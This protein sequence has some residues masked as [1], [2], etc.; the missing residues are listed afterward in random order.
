MQ[1]SAELSDLEL[2]LINVLQV[3]P[4]V[5]W[6]RAGEALGVDPSTVARTWK[7]LAA[8]GRVWVSAY[9]R[10]TPAGVPFVAFIEVGCRVGARTA[11]AD[12]LA[13]RP[14]AATIEHATGGRDLLV[15]VLASGLSALSGVLSEEL[16]AIDGI[17]AVRVQLA[18]VVA[19]EGGGWRLRAVEPDAVR[20]LA[21]DRTEVRFH[22]MRLDEHDVLLVTELGR[23]A[24][25]GYSELAALSGLGISTVRRRVQRLIANGAVSLRCEVAQALSGWP[26]SAAIWC[27]VPP[28]ELEAVMSGFAGMPEV[29]LC[30]ALT[31]GTAN[32]F[33]SLWVR[34]PGELHRLEGQLSAQ[35]RG[36]EVVDRMLALRHIKRMGHLLDAAGRSVG[37]VP[38][39]PA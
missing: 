17:R 34:S 33:V 19:V 20:R 24:R 9:P 36:I 5:S 21:E 8:S 28:A 1:E 26:V 7:S 39:V 11:V 32:L 35:A 6:S 27:R 15:S 16:E 23:D 37:V 38:V 4:R 25:A 13:E 12:A 30:A 3:D 14:W 22:P 29:R 2:R 31:G 18:T 10:A